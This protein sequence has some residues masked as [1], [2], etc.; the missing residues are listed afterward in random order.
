MKCSFS[1]PDADY[2]AS[3]IQA[4]SAKP[5][6]YTAV[7][8]TKT[9]PVR[10]FDNDHQQIVLG[11]GDGVW[12]RAREALL[13]WQQFPSP[14]TRIHATAPG[15][16]SGQVVAVMFQLVGLWWI[17]SARIVYTIDENDRFGFAYGTLPGHVESGEECFWIERDRDGRVH[18]HIKAFSRPAYWMVWLGYPF[19]RYYQRKFVRQS[20]QQMR[21]Y[22]HES[23]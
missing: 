8:G 22:C 5:Y 4:Q 12:E 10:G 2:L 9:G 17:N 15:L 7:N 1:Y 20:L 16:E 11:V 21:K 19:A 23:D 18:Y 13:H 14:W 3:F 6:S